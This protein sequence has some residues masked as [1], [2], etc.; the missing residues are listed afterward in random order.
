MNEGVHGNDMVETTKLL[1][2]HVP[3]MKGDG[4]TPQVFRKTLTGK[5]NQIRGEIHRSHAGALSSQINGEHPRSTSC[6]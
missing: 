3:C 1:V 4:S 2:E 5:L 6:I